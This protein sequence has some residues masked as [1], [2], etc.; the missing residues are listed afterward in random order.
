MTD[1]LQGIKLPG[2]IFQLPSKGIFY[3]NGELADHIQN[4]EIHVHPLSAMD[5]IIL[6]NPDQLFSGE[7]VESVFKRCTDG[8]LKPKELLSRD[9]DALTLYLRT[10]TYGPSFE[11]SAKHTCDG[12]KAHSYVADL[13]QIIANTVF[14]DEST[15]EENYQVTMPNGQV[16]K[17]K[18]VAYK[19]SLDM[20]KRNHGKTQL[21]AD[22]EKENLLT[23]IMGILVSVNGEERQPIL[24]EWVGV[25]TQPYVN[26]L[27]T[28][29]AA[30]DE[31]GPKMVWKCQCK[32]C[33]KEY[34]VEIPVNPVTF[35][36][37]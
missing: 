20:I 29:L 21:T 13:E 7:A 36:T 28:K 14:I 10:V 11:F 24:Q 32:D 5:E 35:F 23:G 26:R 12:A 8:I 2:R 31:W 3:K 18:P 37:E 19:N 6:K 4:G 30:L 27:A 25:I 1:I 33:G 9:V 15:Y 34:D 16:V 22:D 17:L